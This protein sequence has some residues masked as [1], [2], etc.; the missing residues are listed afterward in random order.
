[1][2]TAA[3]AFVD[4]LVAHGVDHVFCVPGESYL[5]ILDALLDAPS[6]RVITCRH[7]AAAANMAE[8]YGKLTGRPGLC[9]VTRGP[10][11][12]HGMIG[13][14]TAQHDQTPMIML[15]GQ[16]PSSHRLRGAFQE[17]NYEAV[18]ASM[19]K[20]VAEVNAPDRMTELLDRAFSAAVSPRSGPVVLSVPED[21]LDGAAGAE[22]SAPSAIRDPAPNQE[23]IATLTRLLADAKRPLIIL[24]GA[25][26]TQAA[27]MDVRLFAETWRV[28]VATSFRRKDYFNNDHGNYIGELGLATNPAM[29]QIVKDA[30]L[31]IAIGARLSD[32]ATGGFMR[33][34][35]AE[36]RKRL[37]HVHAD[38]SELGKVYRPLLAMQAGLAGAA[39]AFRALPCTVQ[40]ESTWLR[41]CRSQ[42]EAHSRPLKVRGAVNLSEIFSNLAALCPDEP[43]VANGAG[44]FAAWLHRFHKHRSFGTQ[45]APTSGAMGYGLPAGLAAKFLFPDR[46]CIA[47]EGD[48]GALMAIQELATAVQFKAAV[49]LI[50]IDNGAYGTIRMHQ[51]RH[52][53]GRVSA[54]TLS[55]PD[56]VALARAFGAEAW[57]ITRTEEFAPAFK[58]A[59]ASGGPCL[60]HVVTSLEDIAPGLAL[61]NETIVQA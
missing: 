12:S 51:S 34:S 36:A 2:R 26:W 60:L 19:T 37:V 27:L 13:I 3:T 32:V 14:H 48:G 50:V 17:M 39:S 31:L 21:M 7:E 58:A 11:A 56:F 52:Y 22:V 40:E 35:Q 28:P 41:Q 23:D 45:L 1:M 44:N 15:I 8:A 59:R 43:I 25:R 49:I 29:D 55:N 38:P 47:V 5:Q 10:G 57:R 54:T 61:E 20:W 4:G 53:P 6:I 42:Y 24:G 30:D 46:T 16:A 18:F 9:L 33:I